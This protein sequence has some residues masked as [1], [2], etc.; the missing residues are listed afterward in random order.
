MGDEQ[1]HQVWAD[2]E[3]GPQS[4]QAEIYCQAQPKLQ[5]KAELALVSINPATH[6][7][8]PVNVY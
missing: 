7:Y 2:G 6:P 5:V 8:P 4:A 1:T 3:R